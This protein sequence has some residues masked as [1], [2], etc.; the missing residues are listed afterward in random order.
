MFFR[1]EE[2]HAPSCKGPVPGPFAQGNIGVSHDPRRALA[3]QNTITQDNTHGLATIQARRIDL[4][5]LTREGPAN[6]QGIE[7]SWRIPFL[8]AVNR[9]AILRGKIVKRPNGDDKVGAGK[10]EFSSANSLRGC[11]QRGIGFTVCPEVSVQRELA[12]G[13]LSTLRWRGQEL[14]TSVIM[15]WHAEKW[16]SPL[17][18]H[19]RMRSEEV[20]SS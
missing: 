14:E 11:L 16:S 7:A 20:I 10:L 19:F 2:I 4:D 15:L 8:L 1:P 12:E 5:G 6:C 13:S 17:L 9:N 3:F 18:K